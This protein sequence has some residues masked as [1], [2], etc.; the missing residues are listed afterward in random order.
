M[1]NAPQTEYEAKFYFVSKE[2]IRQ[3][4]QQV[5]AKLITPERL[6]KIAVFTSTEKSSINGTYA[7]VRDEGDKITMSIKTHAHHG[8]SMEDQKEICLKIDDFE[9]GKLFLE[10]LNLR[11]KAYHEKLRETWHF[12]GAEVEIDSYPAL[13]PYIEIEAK[14]E[15]KVWESAKLLEV[16]QFKS[17]VSGVSFLYSQVYGVDKDI[18]NNHTPVITFENLPSWV[19]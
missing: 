1:S 5:G 19:E 13:E 17:T 12:K 2:K 14:N 15:A 6:L 16:D 11:C 3:K 18:V 8:G 9:Q 4:L 7:R 10:N